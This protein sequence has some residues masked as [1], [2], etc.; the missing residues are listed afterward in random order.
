ML[1]VSQ[2]ELPPVEFSI[3]DFR[4][5]VEKIREAS[6]FSELLDN[7]Q[8]QMCRISKAYGRD[9]EEW[10]KYYKIRVGMVNLLTSFQGYFDCF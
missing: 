5:E 4:T 7:Y 9:D 8:Y 10:K 2:S 6:E 3:S 1:A